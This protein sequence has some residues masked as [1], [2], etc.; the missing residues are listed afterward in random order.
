MQAQGPAEGA[1]RVSVQAGRDPPRC[2]V[3]LELLRPGWRVATLGSGCRRRP[4]RSVRAP[5]NSV[6]DDCSVCADAP[7]AAAASTESAAPE[8][9]PVNPPAWPYW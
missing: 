1:V 2:V 8:P 4:Y 9:M 3:A 7:N 6:A 5:L